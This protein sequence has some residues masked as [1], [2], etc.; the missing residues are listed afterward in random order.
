ML[1]ARASF[2]FRNSLSGAGEPKSL[3]SALSFVQIPV[4]KAFC[5]VRAAADITDGVKSM[6][7]PVIAYSSHSLYCLRNS[8]EASLNPNPEM[9]GSGP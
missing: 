8:E 1:N 7:T 6:R 2:E 9:P 3:N 5:P 4:R